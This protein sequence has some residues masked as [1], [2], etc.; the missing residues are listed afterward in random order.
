MVYE[1]LKNA[2]GEYICQHCGELKKNQN[3]MHYHLKSHE[4]R[5]PYKCIHCPMTFKAKYSL[6]VH[7]DTQ[8]TKQEENLHRCPVAGCKF[9]GSST[10][11]NL[12]IHFVRIHCKEEVAAARQGDSLVCRHCSKEAGSLTA[13]S[14]HAAGCI[15][16]H[17]VERK[18]MFDEL[19]TKGLVQKVE[20][21]E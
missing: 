5:L 2:A 15:E 14:Y 7:T 4:D 19:F 1:Y 16:I 17:N 9:K 18:K 3:T 10:K 11:S 12:L 13:F 21:K 20:S 6:K 8:H